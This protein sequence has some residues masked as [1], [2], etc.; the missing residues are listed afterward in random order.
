MVRKHHALG[1]AYK[2]EQH[3]PGALGSHLADDGL[4]TVRREGNG[5]YMG[6]RSERL[7]PRAVLRHRP[8]RPIPQ[9]LPT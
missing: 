9:A 8:N 7:F 5:L 1:V 3:D 4:R 6:K 2:I